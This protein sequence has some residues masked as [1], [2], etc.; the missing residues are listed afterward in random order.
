MKLKDLQADLAKYQYKEEAVLTDE[1]WEVLTKMFA[2]EGSF[3][4]LFKHMCILESTKGTSMVYDIE[5]VPD[6][7]FTD[8]EIVDYIKF[9][10]MATQH[11]RGKIESLR[12]Y[13]A[14]KADKKVQEEEKRIIEQN[15]KN[16]KTVA[17]KEAQ[18]KGI[19]P[20]L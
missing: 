9:K 20:T 16:K 11:I 5:Q 2:V 18:E 13:F 4:V 8:R 7:G 10:K 17:E 1:D 19:S 6:G 14:V 15:E 3:K 12:N